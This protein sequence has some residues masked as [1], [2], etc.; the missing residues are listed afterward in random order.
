MLRLKTDMGL[1]NTDESLADGT[2]QEFIEI[3]ERYC[4]KKPSINPAAPHLPLRA[5]I[6]RR[7]IN[8]L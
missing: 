7:A 3:T 4:F 2:F 6:F 5:A 1:S 8:G